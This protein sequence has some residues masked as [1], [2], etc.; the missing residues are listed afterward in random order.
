[1]SK[2]FQ[3]KS[4]YHL[5]IDDTDSN[6]TMCTTYL[7]TLLVEL[8]QENKVVF[9]DFPKLIRL[10]PNI[11]YKTRG[12][13]AVAIDFICEENKIEEIWQM[14]ISTTV[15]HSD[16]EDEN[17]HPG[18]VLV[19]NEIPSY[20][21]DLYSKA[22]YD[23]IS[24]EE[25]KGKLK[26]FTNV[27]FF[28]LKKG[29]GLIGA[30][31][32]I[33]A[34][35]DQDYT[36]ELIAY[37][38]KDNWGLSTRKIDKESVY[39]ADAAT[40]LTFSNIDKIHNDIMILPHGPDPV[41][42]G[43]RGET[44]EA[45][46]QMWTMLKPKEPIQNIMIFRSN[47]H[48]RVH[49]PFYARSEDVKPYHSVKVRGLVVREP[50]YIEGAHVIFSLKLEKKTVDCAA[51]EPTK[52]FRNIVMSLKK[53]DYIEVCG[54]IRALEEGKNLTINL[55]EFTPIKLVVEYSNITPKCPIC[56]VTLKSSGKNAG[57]KCKKCHYKTP[58]KYYIKSLLPRSIKAGIRYVTPICAQRHLTKPIAREV[59]LQY[60]TSNQENFASQFSHFLTEHKK[61]F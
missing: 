56:G 52:K 21:N 1:M 7:G 58:V 24:I 10:N 22:L 42:C 61:Y 46:L 28:H 20:F 34:S 11:P 45:V 31:C 2:E 25:V 54:G 43:I 48:T 59:S 36:F 5:G 26:S 30:S 51:Y 53:G 29:R 40:P 44:S 37:R 57:F 3:Q 15:K 33:G 9:I 49:F 14:I 4:V 8:L 18:V 38:T 13:G 35:L 60:H 47:Q 41:Y 12:N 55:E 23:V 32:A 50:Y 6:R 17:T 27:R 16:T 39:K 19:K